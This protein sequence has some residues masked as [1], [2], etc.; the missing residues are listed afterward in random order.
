MS[1]PSVLICFLTGPERYQ[2][3]APRLTMRLIEA[4]HSPDVDV[5]VRQVFG[6]YGYAAARNRCVEQFFMTSGCDWLCM[7]DNDNI[8]PVNFVSRVIEFAQSRPDVDIV[9][10][11]YYMRPELGGNARTLLCTGWH[12]ST[13]NEYEM[14]FQLKPEWQEIDVGGA[15][16]MFVRRDVF[17]RLGKPWFRIPERAVQEHLMNGA[18]EDCAFCDDA[19]AAGFHVWSHGGLLASHLHTVDLSSVARATVAREEEDLAI[20]KQLG[21]RVPVSTTVKAAAR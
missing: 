20:F 8:P 21:L 6:V 15:G 14:P 13:P 7:V 17:V 3:P 16:C 2:W 10:L 9:A 11:P 19:K 18:S 1:K 4:T 5:D 12:T